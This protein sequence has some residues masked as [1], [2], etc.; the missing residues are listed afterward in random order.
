M[1]SA[2]GARFDME[3]DALLILALSILA[4]QFGKAGPW[5]LASGLLRYVF[6]IAGLALPWLRAPLPPSFRRKSVA[7]LQTIA[8][9]FTVAPFVSPFVSGP[10]AAFALLC[11]SLSFLADIVRLRREAV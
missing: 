8:L 10:I 4:W 3:T 2:F 6:V 5:V 11:L 7:V 9:L 1:S